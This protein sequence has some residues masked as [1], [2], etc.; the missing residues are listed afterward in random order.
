MG[1]S[2]S[3][4]ASEGDAVE[5]IGMEG[6][7]VFIIY[8][9]GGPD[10]EG[11]GNGPRGWMG[12]NDDSFRIA[13]PF[14]LKNHMAVLLNVKHPQKITDSGGLE[15]NQFTALNMIFHLGSPYSVRACAYCI[16]SLQGIPRCNC[17]LEGATTDCQEAMDLD[18]PAQPTAISFL[19]LQVFREQ[20]WGQ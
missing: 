6:Q 11:I 19:W 2:L 14:C 7:R 12:N 1:Q 16:K 17:Q 10:Y 15:W 5:M 13:S 18:R 20:E 4:G 3:W 8:S 9:H